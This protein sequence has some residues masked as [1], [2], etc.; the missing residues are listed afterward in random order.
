MFHYDQSMEAWEPYNGP[1]SAT[2]ILP[3]AVKSLRPR[4]LP[5]PPRT[6]L[7]FLPPPRNIARFSLSLLRKI[8]SDMELKLEATR[9]G[10]A[11]PI[12]ANPPSS[13]VHPALFDISAMLSVRTRAGDG[14]GVQRLDFDVDLSGASPGIVY[15][16]LWSTSVEEPVIPLLLASRSVLLVAHEMGKVFKD[17][18]HNEDVCG[19]DLL[20]DVAD[21]LAATAPTSVPTRLVPMNSFHSDLDKK[22]L[23]VAARDILEWSRESGLS[24]LELLI[25]DQIELLELP[26]KMPIP[27]SAFWSGYWTAHGLV[28][29]LAFNILRGVKGW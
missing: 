6:S 8:P 2:P 21:I 26:E 19:E 13:D 14:G 4:L 9:N 27:L 28:F 17:L 15:F 25:K 29:S 3:D 12:R 11:L 22:R 10:I 16:N 24:S 5:L 20:A 23:I 7:C 18:G 1:L